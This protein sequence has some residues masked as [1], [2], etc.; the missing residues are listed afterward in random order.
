MYVCVYGT[1][2]AIS[3]MN[4][5][6]LCLVC[7]WDTHTVLAGGCVGSWLISMKTPYFTPIIWNLSMP[8][9]LK[10][11]LIV[12]SKLYFSNL[13]WPASSEKI[14]QFCTKINTKNINFF[15]YFTLNGSLNLGF[16]S[17]DLLLFFYINL[18]CF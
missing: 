16:R 18:H 12:F 14:T 2:Q 17:K 9:H 8:W 3:Q 11:T 6:N 1:P 15:I 5:T 10:N 13:I 4:V 7:T